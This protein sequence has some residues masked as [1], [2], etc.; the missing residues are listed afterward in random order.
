MQGQGALSIS[1]YNVLSSSVQILDQLQNNDY[2]TVLYT[3]ATT[4]F[5]PYYSQAQVDVLVNN[6][7]L[8]SNKSTSTSLGTSDTLYPTQNAVKTY[9][10]GKK[11]KVI[12]YNRSQ[13]TFP[14]V[15]AA[16]FPL[17]SST[18]FELAVANLN[19]ATNNALTAISSQS[20]WA[21]PIGVVPFDCKLK[22]VIIN[23]KQVFGSWQGGTLRCVI[24]SNRNIDSSAGGAINYDNQ[25]I[26]EFSFIPGVTG[27]GIGFE[28]YTSTSS[29]IV[30]AFHDI[31]VFMSFSRT[32]ISVAPLLSVY[33]EF[34]RV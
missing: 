3:N 7:E 13:W 22:R 23:G 18:N 9:V 2:I 32:G 34:E 11:E 33:V 8:L 27:S 1:Q 30:P 24:G 10:D 31:L 12:F 25:V 4:G 19:F 5:Q 20:P 14:N 17:I 16:P 15:A 28:N 6:K 21:M 26:D 29:V